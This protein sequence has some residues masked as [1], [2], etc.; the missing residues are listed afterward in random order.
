MF[1]THCLPGF[2][3]SPPR[4]L[5]LSL[6]TCYDLPGLL[7]PRQQPD[8]ASYWLFISAPVSAYQWGRPWPKRLQRHLDLCSPHAPLCPLILFF[9]MALITETFTPAYVL[10]LLQGCKVYEGR[11]LLTASSQ[12]PIND[13]Y[14]HLWNKW[15][16]LI[17]FKCD[18]YRKPSMI[19]TI[20]LSL[21]KSSLPQLSTHSLLQCF[22]HCRVVSWLIYF[23]KNSKR[24]VSFSLMNP[25]SLDNG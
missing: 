4:L 7:L 22:S 12:G 10:C 5:H 16:L 17:P 14:Q 6:C 24:A 18:F 15:Y 23:L 2:S 13:C 11:I 19:S 8:F 3:L 1:Q 21:G 25:Q 20:N 9:P